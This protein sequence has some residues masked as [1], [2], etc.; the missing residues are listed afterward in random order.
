M[1]RS[2]ERAVNMKPHLVAYEYG[3]GA[4]WGYVMA[5]SRDAVTRALPEVEVFDE[6]PEWMTSDDI[7]HLRHHTTVDVAEVSVGTILH[8]K[9]VSGQAVRY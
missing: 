9:K 3:S 1:V 8:G 7:E 5:P 4:A 6:P 2:V